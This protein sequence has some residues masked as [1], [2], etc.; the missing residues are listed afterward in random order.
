MNVLVIAV[1]LALLASCSESNGGNGGTGGQGNGEYLDPSG[2]C[3]R[4]L[5]PSIFGCADDYDAALAATNP[6]G[7]ACAGPAGERLLFFRDCTP[8]LRCAY[9]R[10]ARALVGAF[11]GDDVPSHCGGSYSV[12]AGDFPAEAVFNGFDRDL[13]CRAPAEASVSPVLNDALGENDTVAAGD[14]CRSGLDQCR[15]SVRAMVCA[16]GRGSIAGDGACRHCQSD[17]E[18]Q[19]EYRY[20]SLVTTCGPAGLCLFGSALVGQCSDIDSGCSTAKAAF[21][22]QDGVCDHCSSNQQCEAVGPYNLCMSGECM[23]SEPLP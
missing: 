3:R 4:R 5:E 21:V 22:C 8:T 18:C 13:N 23:R 19:A 1:A 6:C 12:V 15:G 16:N 7:I 9:D 11:Y 20:A 10:E 14:P 17:A 2:T